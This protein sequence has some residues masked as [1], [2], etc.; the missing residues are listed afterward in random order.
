MIVMDTICPGSVLLK[1]WMCSGSRFHNICESPYV[2]HLWNGGGFTFFIIII[3]TKS[4]KLFIPVQQIQKENL[5][6]TEKAEVIKTG[7][8]A[9]K[10]KTDR[11]RK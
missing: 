2:L 8:L 4:C 5:K 1:Q 10:L 9:V 3:V 11:K 7:G 6:H